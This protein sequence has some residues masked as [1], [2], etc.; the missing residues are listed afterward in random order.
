MSIFLLVGSVYKWGNHLSVLVCHV[1]FTNTITQ[2]HKHIQ[3]YIQNI[4]K[5]P[6]MTVKYHTSRAQNIQKHT[7]TVRIFLQ[8]P[9]AAGS[10]PQIWPD[11]GLWLQR[12]VSA[13]SG[14]LWCVLPCKKKGVPGSW[15]PGDFSD[16]SAV[17]L[18]GGYWSITTWH[19]STT[20][21]VVFMTHTW[22]AAHRP[23]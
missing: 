18:E 22:G 5:P 2:K 3:L 21:Y 19:T 1:V 10:P 8:L 15:C 4:P 7:S 14:W 6:N 13:L 20:C 9:G 23:F 12:S 17:Q 16:N 11:L